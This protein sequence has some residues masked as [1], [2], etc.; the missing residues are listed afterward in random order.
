MLSI[1]SLKQ[2]FPHADIA[3]L[4]EDTIVFNVGVFK[5]RV[6][7]TKSG[8]INFEIIVMLPGKISHLVQ[9]KRGIDSQELCYQ[10]IRTFLLSQQK[11]IAT[12]LGE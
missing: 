7:S 8:K 9:T 5:F 3:L 4:T 2:Y 11:A 1:S 12:T 10:E 6:L